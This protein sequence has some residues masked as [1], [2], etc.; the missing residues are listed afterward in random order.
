MKNKV[1]TK[2]LSLQEL[3]EQILAAENQVSA[4]RYSHALSP[5]QNPMQIRAAKK[6]VARLKTELQARAYQFIAE[7]VKSNELSYDNLDDFS[8]QGTPLVMKKAKLKKVINKLA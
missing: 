8:Q 3:K 1:D 7:K 4:L 5:L 2:K 6:Q